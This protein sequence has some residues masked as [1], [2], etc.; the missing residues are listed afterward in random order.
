LLDV[1]D[2]AWSRGLW[3]TAAYHTLGY[4]SLLLACYLALGWTCL[5]DEHQRSRV[6]KAYFLSAT[7]STVG[8]GDI[9]PT[10]QATRLAAVFLLP[11]GLIIIGFLLSYATA[12]EKS[13]K[14]RYCGDESLTPQELEMRALFEALDADGD[15]VLTLDE[16][17]KGAKIMSM[18]EQQ[19][20]NLYTDLDPSGK[21]SVR[22]PPKQPPRWRSTAAGKA[23]ILGFKIYGLVAV[24][25]VYFKVWEDGAP[26]MTWVDACYMATVVATSIGFGD[27][28]PSS[29]SGRLFLTGYMLVA[30]VVV[31]QAL[32][33]AINVYVEDVVGARIVAKLSES[34][35]WLHKVGWGWCVAGRR[36]HKFSTHIKVNRTSKPGTIG[37]FRLLVKK[38]G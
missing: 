13:V 36:G 20:R 7:L 4:A 10:M 38:M 2:F 27:L 14:P 32:S 9:A 5:V 17:V 22:A 21:G 28:V 31:G 8:L 23:W 35:T 16:C 34:T 30:T 26:E 1:H 15:G 6:W 33:D 18:T 19:A 29:D 25:A 24:G 3:R 12:M 37:L 11:L